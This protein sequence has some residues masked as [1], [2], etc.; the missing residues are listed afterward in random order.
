MAGKA[1]AHAF[2]C[3]PHIPG[4]YGHALAR[5]PSSY[6]LIIRDRS[7]LRHFLA[8]VDSGG[9]MDRTG[10]MDPRAALKVVVKITRA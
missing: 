3:Y 8:R 6:E 7:L 4:D 9:L 10:E 5:I 2:S 1:L